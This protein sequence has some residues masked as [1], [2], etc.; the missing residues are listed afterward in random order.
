M[1][2]IVKTISFI[3]QKGG[4]G[5]STSSYAL[6]SEL[7]EIG[8]HILLIDLDPQASLTSLAGIHEPDLVQNS[9]T[10]LLSD[11]I[12]DKVIS[13]LDVVK[14]IGENLDLIP[15]NIQL[16]GI[17][18]MLVNAMSRENILRMCI[19]Q[20]KDSYDYVII[21]CMPSLGMLTINALSASDSVI[22]PV[23]A[24]FLSIKGL[25]Q[26]LMTIKKVKRQINPR[27]KIDGILLT[28]VDK[29]TNFSKD[30]ITLLHD[31][32]GG[33]INIFYSEIPRSIKV[34]EASAAGVSI[35]K[36]DP[37]GKASMAYEAFA[38]EVVALERNR[39]KNQTDPIR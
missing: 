6:A 4:V 7:S 9:V 12:H 30:I 22:I 3:N 20:I 17:E 5:K 11:A 35:F 21:D 25:E 14:Q 36:Y 34:A 31:A 33:K 24:D 37:K 15:S 27:L 16:S 28:M 18:S 1:F 38:Q 29:R 23:Q 2:H 19:S 10:D 8:A 13:T 26:L 39:A 32:Y